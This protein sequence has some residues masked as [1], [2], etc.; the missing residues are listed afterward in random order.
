MNMPQWRKTVEVCKYPQLF[1][2][3]ILTV[4]YGQETCEPFRVGERA[5]VDM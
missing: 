1:Q 3:A 4:R 5:V 2:H